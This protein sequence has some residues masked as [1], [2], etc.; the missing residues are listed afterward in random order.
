MGRADARFL[1]STR[2]VVSL[3]LVVRGLRLRTAP[4]VAVI[5]LLWTAVDIANAQL[6]A[7]DQ[8]PLST[9]TSQRITDK[10]PQPQAPAGADDCFCCSHTVQA[11]TVSV[12][13]PLFAPR[14]GSSQIQARSP[15]TIDRQ[16]DHPPQAF[17]RS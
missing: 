9:V 2:R 14:E 4:F 15:F 10:T 8:Q 6:C 17:A 7:V 1:D 16:I 11:A 12:S 5:L 3:Q 13:T